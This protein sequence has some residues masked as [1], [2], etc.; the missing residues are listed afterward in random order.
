MMEVIILF[1]PGLPACWAP[2]RG[3][4]SGVVTGLCRQVPCQRNDTEPSARPQCCTLTPAA[5]DCSGSPGK[6]AAPRWGRQRDRGL[7]AHPWWMCQGSAWLLWG[8]SLALLHWWVTVMVLVCGRSV[9]RIAALF[10]WGPGWSSTPEG[11]S[12]EARAALWEE[13][14]V[15][16]CLRQLG[17]VTSE[18]PLRFSSWETFGTLHNKPR[19][20]QEADFLLQVGEL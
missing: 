17:Q 3:S 6:P 8:L 19:V 1:H 16:E 15:R 20:H 10:L 9:L 14:A 2:R 18:S 4:E 13:V 12:A 11:V 7:E 5:C